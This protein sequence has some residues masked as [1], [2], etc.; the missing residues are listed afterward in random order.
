[1]ISLVPLSPLPADPTFTLTN[2][3]TAL[4]SVDNQHLCTAIG[5]EVPSKK[6]VSREGVLQYFI[7]T[8]PDAPWQFLAGSLYKQEEQAALELVTKYFQRQ[9]GMGG[10]APGVQTW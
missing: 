1:M 8:V 7:S 4:E 10:W 2:V 5:L 3:T 6:C 9:P